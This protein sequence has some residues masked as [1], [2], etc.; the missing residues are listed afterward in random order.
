MSRFDLLNGFQN[1]RHTGLAQSLEKSI[2][3]SS[4]ASNSFSPAFKVSIVCLLT[5]S[6]ES[7]SSASSSSSSSLLESFSGSNEFNRFDSIVQE[8][9]THDGILMAKDGLVTITEVQPPDLN[10]LIGGGSDD[11]LGIRGDI[12]GQNRQLMAVKGDEELQSV[13]EENLDSVVQQRNSQSFSAGEASL[14]LYE[15]EWYSNVLDAVEIN[16]SN[17]DEVTW[18]HVTEEILY[19]DLIVE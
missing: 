9:N 8:S 1:I 12:N 15:M 10:V 18:A 6:E 7:L 17:L 4:K 16:R 2:T 11:Q 14:E 5:C 3:N 13:K 19:R